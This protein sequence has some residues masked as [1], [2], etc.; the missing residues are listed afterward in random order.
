MK[1]E[2][3]TNVAEAVDKELEN[4]VQQ[5]TKTLKSKF[6]ELTNKIFKELDLVVRE[7]CSAGKAKPKKFKPDA[8]FEELKESVARDV[9][10]WRRDWEALKARLPDSND[11]VTD[12]KDKE[13]L[14]ADASDYFKKIPRNA[15]GNIDFDDL[16][17]RAEAMKQNKDDKK[18]EKQVKDPEKAPKAGKK[19]AAASGMEKGANAAKKTIPTS[20]GAGKGAAAQAGKV[21]TEPTEES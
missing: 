13:E 10:A 9:R 7:V 17:R 2:V 15:E 18:K 12:E 5:C 3:F 11:E 1:R 6:T 4:A 19:Q 14:K 21:K 20:N 8:G 16:A